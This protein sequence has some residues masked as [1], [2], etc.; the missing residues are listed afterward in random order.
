[1]NA[2]EA[3]EIIKSMYKGEP[4]DIQ[5]KALNMAYKALKKQMAEPLEDWNE[6][7]G[8]CLWWKFPIE[9]PPYLGSP[10]DTTWAELEYD[11]YYT[12]F[13]RLAIPDIKI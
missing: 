13:T 12:H 5:I 1:M 8:D 6:E 9:E 4:T 11:R 10:L 2:L 7:I 3:T